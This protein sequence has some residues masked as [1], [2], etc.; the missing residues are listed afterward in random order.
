MVNFAHGEVPNSSALGHSQI[1]SCIG[2]G[3]SGA[4][5]NGRGGRQRFWSV[6]H[7]TSTS[8]ILMYEYVLVPCKS[9]LVPCFT[10][11]CFYE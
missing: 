7:S 11:V 8:F 2:G 3:E 10:D 1:V 6:C 5:C 4:E 9:V